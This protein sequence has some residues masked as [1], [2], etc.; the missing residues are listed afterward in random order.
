MED[1]TCLGLRFVD[2]DLADSGRDLAADGHRITRV[3]D[4]VHDHLFELPGV[5]LDPP[6][7]RRPGARHLDTLAE[8]RTQHRLEIMNRLGQSQRALARPVAPGLQ[9]LDAAAVGRPPALDRAS[10]HPRVPH[11]VTVRVHVLPPRY[12]AHRL[13]RGPAAQDERLDLGEYRVAQERFGGIETITL[14]P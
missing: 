8:D 2:C 11:S 12:L 13:A 10:A 9:G 1:V 3:H 6:A 5:D 14:V 7:V 4:Q